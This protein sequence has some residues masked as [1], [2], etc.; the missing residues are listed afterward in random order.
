M[1]KCLNCQR[2]AK[3]LNNKTPI[4]Y[5]PFAWGNGDEEPQH[6]YVFSENTPEC[7]DG[8]LQQ[9]DTIKLCEV[10]NPIIR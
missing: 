3:S 2:I 1:Y 5:K 7:E 4:G 9:L 8:E 6:F 10:S